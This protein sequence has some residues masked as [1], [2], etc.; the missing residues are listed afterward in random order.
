[1]AQTVLRVRLF[2]NEVEKL[3]KGAT[4]PVVLYQANLG[5]QVA[6]AARRLAP[7]GKGDGPHL[8]DNIDSKLVPSS[9]GYS[10]E[11]TAGVPHAIFVHRGTR[12]HPIDGNPLLVFDWPKAGGTVFLRHV[13]HPG[14]K[15]N[16]FMLEAARSVG[17]D[18]R[19]S[20]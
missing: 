12:P 19:E 8:A 4:G 6:G 2:Q 13:N 10:V 7:R 18:A 11:I 17:L 9:D 20:R 1:M 5:R 14:T 16:K 3:L 15:P